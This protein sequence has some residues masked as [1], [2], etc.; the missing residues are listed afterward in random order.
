ML[1]ALD[2]GQ[3]EQIDKGST[4]VA[5]PIKVR[6]QIIGVVDGR[7]S[8]HAG[9]WSA[10]ELELLEALTEQLNVAIE[11]A[12]LYQDSRRRAAREELIGEI[13]AQMRGTL[14]VETIIETAV[15]E[16]G[17]SLDLSALEVRLSLGKT[18]NATVD[19]GDA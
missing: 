17:Q 13:T 12:R 3:M 5:I 15:Q 16:I 11:D 8:A 2:T 1:Q 18:K 19:G 7:K 9:G 10:E 4:S 6:D 14:D